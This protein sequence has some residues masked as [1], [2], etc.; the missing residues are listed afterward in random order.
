MNTSFMRNMVSEIFEKH[1]RKNCFERTVKETKEVKASFVGENLFHL[2]AALSGITFVQPA[3]WVVADLSNRREDM[4]TYYNGNISFAVNPEEAKWAGI[5]YEMIDATLPNMCS[6]K[7]SHL[8]GEVCPF[9]TVSWTVN[10]ERQQIW[11]MENL[12]AFA[13]DV[14]ALM[15][16]EAA[17]VAE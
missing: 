17:V 8:Y 4:N 14:K 5:F 16:K 2:L 9:I 11:T 3:F 12:I 7:L 6:I 15:N 1:A 10:N 13:N